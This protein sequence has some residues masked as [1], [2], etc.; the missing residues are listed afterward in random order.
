MLRDLT[1]LQDNLEKYLKTTDTVYIIG[2]KEADFDSIGAAVGVSQICKFYNKNSYI[3]LDESLEDMEPGVKKVKELV[4]DKCNIIN[5]DEY[6]E[7]VINNLYG[8]EFYSLPEDN[9]EEMLKISKIPKSLLIIVDTNKEYMLA[10]KDYLRN[11]RRTIIIDHHKT[12]EKATCKATYSYINLDAS[13]A[14]EIVANY[15][16]SKKIKIDKDVANALAAG[17]YLDTNRFKKNTTAVTYDAVEHLTLAGANTDTINQ[18]FLQDF[19]TDKIIYNLVFDDDNTKHFIKLLKNNSVSITLNRANPHCIYRKESIAKAADRIQSYNSTDTAI[20]MGYIDPKT[21][22]ISLR[23]NGYVDCD[24]LI[25]GYCTDKERIGGGTAKSAGAKLYN[26][27][28]IEEEENLIEYLSQLN[29]KYIKRKN[30][31]SIK[32]SNR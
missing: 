10:N 32:P 3:I 7:K 19:E 21:I 26:K 9:Q 31:N 11:Y 18:L 30:K 6:K 4:K 22:T 29:K 16:Y 17:I 12:E 27:D 8:E 28:I 23:S 1:E 15:I 13:S 14:S 24:K 25:K 2:H 20:V 5:M